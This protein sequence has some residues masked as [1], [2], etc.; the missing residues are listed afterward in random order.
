VN[1]DLCFVPASHEVA[2]KLPAVSGSS[3]RLV[4]EQPATTDEQRQYPGRIFEDESLDYG[5]AMLA[6]VGAS[7]ELRASSPQPLTAEEAAQASLKAHKRVL[8]QEEAELRRQRR[9]VR[10]RRQ[11]ED[12]AWVALRQERRTQQAKRS[13]QTKAEQAASRDQGQA[14]DRQ[15]RQLR[16]QR[17]QQQ[18]ERIDEDAHWR[19]QRQSLR[20]RLSNL[21]IVA[22]WIAI[23]VITDNCTRQ[24]L[25]L[26]LFVAGPR[27]TA[28]VIVEALRALLPSELLFLISDRGVHFTA[29]AFRQLALSEE[30]IHVLIARHRPQSNGI[31]ERFVRTLKEWL[32]D[33]SW[34]TDEELAQLLAQF[35]AEYNDRPHRGLAIPGLSPNEFANR[36]WLM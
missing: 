23:L 33:K 36:I 3:G 15:W 2:D 12:A 7:L 8:R 13:R 35:V 16:Q 18:Q 31:A 1:V 34:T 24:C 22:A 14:A 28:E 30:F 17:Q 10:Q 9:Q 20:Q 6:F 4:V 11:Q 5:E 29:Q 19:Q 26:P 21:P 25:G 27:V 32:A